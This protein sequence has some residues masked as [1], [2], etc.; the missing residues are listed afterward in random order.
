MN[1]QQLSR[2]ERSERLISIHCYLM[3]KSVPYSIQL[4]RT[5]QAKIVHIDQKL[6]FYVDKFWKFLNSSIQP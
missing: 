2:L 6:G 5:L 3:R 4:K 1:K